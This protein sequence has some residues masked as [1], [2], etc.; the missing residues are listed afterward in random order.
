MK[1][2]HIKSFRFLFSLFNETMRYE[3]SRFESYVLC[4]VQKHWPSPDTLSS[5]GFYYEPS[6]SAMSCFCCGATVVKWETS[7]QDVEQ[8]HR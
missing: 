6:K 2:D 4:P 1:N 5:A 7:S 8:K 3:K